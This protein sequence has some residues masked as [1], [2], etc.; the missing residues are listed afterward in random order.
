[1]HCFGRPPYRRAGYRRAG[2]RR[3][4]SSRHSRRIAGSWRVGFPALAF[5]LATPSEAAPQEAPPSAGSRIHRSTPPPNATTHRAIPGRRFDAGRFKRWFYGDNYRDL[6]TTAIDFPVLDLDRVGSGLTPLRTGGFGQSISLHFT[7]KDGLRYTVRSLDKDPT[8]RLADELRNTLVSGVLHDLISTLLPA[9]GLVVDPLME[10][11]GILHSKHTLAVIPDDPGLGEYRED[12]AGLIGSLQIHPSEGPDDT[13]GFAGSRKVSGTETLWEDLEESACERVDARAFL[14]AR[15][16]DFLVN[17]KDRH[18]GQWRWARFPGGDCYT[19]LP[20]PEDR[21]QAF[22]HYGGAAMTLARWF[23]PVVI[24]FGHSFPNLTGLTGTAWELDRQFLVEL[25]KPAWDEV[26]ATF[27]SELPDSVIEDAVRRLP[28][29]YYRMVGESLE[30]KLKAR[31]DTLPEFVNRYYAL[32][33]RQAEIQATDED[34]Y[35]RLEHLANGDLAVRVGLLGD[36]GEQVESP[37]FERTFR[38]RET[39]EVRLYLRGGADRAE[40]V[41]EEGSITVRIDG[42]GG[43]D[44]FANASA[45][46]ASRTRFYDY[47]GNN[48]FTRGNGARIDER[49]YRRPPGAAGL[50]TPTNLRY[51]LDWGMVGRTRPIVRADPDLGLFVQMLH[52]RTYFGF[53]KDPFAS[54]H[55][56]SVGV[57]SEGYKPIASYEGV[58]RHLRHNV[59]LRLALEYSGLVVTRFTGFGN[60]SRL[61]HPS[62]FYKLRQGTFL[63]APALEFR[64]GGQEVDASADETQLHRPELAVRLGPVVKWSSTPLDENRDNFIGSLDEPLYGTGSFGQIGAESAIRYDGRDSPAYPTS[65]FLGRVTAAGYLG[66][67]DADEAFGSVD[68]ELRTYLTAPIPTHP[69]LALRAGGKKLWG[70]YPFLESAFVGGPGRVGFSQQQGPV[71]G[72]RQNRFAGDASLYANAEL[73]LKLARVN[74]VVPGEFG[75]FAAADVGRVYYGGDPDHADHRGVADWDRGGNDWHR[76]TGGGLWLSLLERRTAVSVALMKGRDMTS[77]YL[78]GYMF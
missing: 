34:E 50:E 31:R 6:W 78:R 77:V 36:S 66:A 38:R 69:T 59:D 16:M 57:A 48:A 75:V 60:D 25:D 12:Y 5:A 21:D 17:D 1:M 30:E 72:F 37:Y 29:P 14:K 47:R 67:W 65:G 26:V 10:A 40:V 51:A 49:P 39:D 18:A 64:G 76:G 42:G 23:V 45:A 33:T 35:A 74:V 7:G 54:Q 3:P 52:N 55:S 68:G 11:T 43:S 41:G 46:P 53:R 20:I 61:A 56:L 19:W 4:S 15:L 27:R 71:R 73:R 32:I 2:Y 28:E 24:D 62:S 58:F 44:T 13:P 70:K 63:L 22:I 8:R 9:A